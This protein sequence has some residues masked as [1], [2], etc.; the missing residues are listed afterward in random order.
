MGIEERSERI[1]KKYNE[2][3]EKKIQLEAKHNML[4]EEM[5]TKYGVSSLEEFRAKAHACENDIEMY[6]KK[7]MPLL[8]ELEEGLG[9]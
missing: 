7:L 6:E 5:N 1:L 4:L 3:K 2:L 8:E 9:L